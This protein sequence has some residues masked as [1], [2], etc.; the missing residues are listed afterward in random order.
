[1][2]T[3]AADRVESRLERAWWRRAV[4]VLTQPRSVFAALRDDESEEAA[5]ARQEP[6]LAIVLL[7]GIVGVLAS[8]VADTLLDNPLRSAPVVAVWAFVGG[9][10]YGAV[11]YFLLGVM[12]LLGMSV[13]GSLVT[14][15]MARHLLAYAAVPVAVSLVLWAPKLALYGGDWF[16]TG[17]D[18]GGGGA[19][20][21]GL[22]QAGFAVWALALIAI[23]IKVVAE[24]TWARTLAAAAVAAALPVAVTA[25][26]AGIG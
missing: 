15:R 17:G 7:A 3:E 1:M 9:L 14:F 6:V 23:G 2:A 20:V 11:A 10:M 5:H 8:P 25:Q 16:R 4:L 19:M 24:L 21:F 13:A 22:L 12:T 18:D 26:A